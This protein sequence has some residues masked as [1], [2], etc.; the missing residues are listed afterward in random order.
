VREECQAVR[1]QKPRRSAQEVSGRNRAEISLSFFE[2]FSGGRKI[3]N[4]EKTFLW[5]VPV[6]GTAAG[7]LP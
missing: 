5:G 7:R 2:F 3:R 1:A 6:S 4:A